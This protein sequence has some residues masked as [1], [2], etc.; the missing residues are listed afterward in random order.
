MCLRKKKSWIVNRKNINSFFVKFWEK[1]C[2]FSQFS[3]IEKTLFGFLVLLEKFY[4]FFFY[5]VSF[6]KRF[7]LKP[8]FSR[9]KVLSIG[10]ISVGGTGKSVFVS[11]LTKNLKNKRIAII[12]RGYGSKAEKTGK[13]FL[14]KP[15]GLNKID[16]SFFGDEAIM[17]SRNTQVPVVVGANRLKSCLLLEDKLNSLDSVI[18][19]D[20]YQNFKLKK[21]FEILLLDATK[22]FENGH[23]LPAGRLR[24]KD[25]SRADVIIL[26]HVNS[27]LSKDLKNLKEK[28]S[29]TFNK[30]NIF[31]G[32]HDFSGIYLNDKEKIKDKEFLGKK[33]LAFA[34]IGSF[35]SFKRSLN[36]LKVKSFL[37]KE[38]PDH[39]NYLKKDFEEVLD[40]LKC[41]KVDAII[42]TQKDWVKLEAFI[43]DEIDYPIYVLR[44]DFKFLI[45]EEE[46]CFFDKISKV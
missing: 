21:N 16:S 19:D 37:Y 43:Q 23:C 15:E 40:Y 8:H 22:P 11:F 45:K 4:I 38:F 42:T 12:L 2:D 7:I 26:T 32:Y 25:T 36:N 33:V 13:S 31:S 30:N 41:K 24:E 3:F 28:L 5:I 18:L 29:V 39:Y 20:A 6:F 9:F 27:I 34:G 1:S 10:N 35:D 44:I 14:L 17:L 46:L